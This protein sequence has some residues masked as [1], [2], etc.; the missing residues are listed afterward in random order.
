M[1][2]L[3][4]AQDIFSSAQ[5]DRMLKSLDE[6]VQVYTEATLILSVVVV[7]F[8]AWLVFCESR[9][10]KASARKPSNHQA[11]QERNLLQTEP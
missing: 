6:W 8:L 11:L 2:N 7:G 10:S 1:L 5:F 9:Q 4:L 3:M